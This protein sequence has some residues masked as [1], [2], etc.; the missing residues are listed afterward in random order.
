[1]HYFLDSVQSMISVGPR[2]FF[3]TI[4]V[5]IMRNSHLLIPNKVWVVDGLFVFDTLW[6]YIPCKNLH[7]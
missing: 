6:V 7:T 4:Q 1:M 2:S 5:S 3:N